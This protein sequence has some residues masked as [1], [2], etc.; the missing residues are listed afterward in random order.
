MSSDPVGEFLVAPFAY[1]DWAESMQMVRLPSG[2]PVR[3]QIGQT[4]PNLIRVRVDVPSGQTYDSVS[5]AADG[6]HCYGCGNDDGPMWCAG[7]N[8]GY[9]EREPE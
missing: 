5:A 6:S 3:I 7:A 4:G 9:L 8:R 1:E 2:L